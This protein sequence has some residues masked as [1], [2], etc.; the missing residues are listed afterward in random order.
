[1]FFSDLLPKKELEIV[2][3]C[4][5]QEKEKSKQKQFQTTKQKKT[6][7]IIVH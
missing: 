6:R 5:F 4:C 2:L 3:Q 7:E 1:M